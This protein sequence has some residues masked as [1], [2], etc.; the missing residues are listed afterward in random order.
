MRSGRLLK[1]CILN[2]LHFM[3]EKTEIKQFA[4]GHSKWLRWHYPSNEVRCASV[5][6]I[7]PAGRK[8]V[9]VLVPRLVSGRQQVLG[10]HTGP[11]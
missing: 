3:D 4:S 11:S 9:R 2:S 5:D 10:G 7:L 1:N 6:R 8:D